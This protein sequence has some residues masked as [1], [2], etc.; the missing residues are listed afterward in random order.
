MNLF[1]AVLSLAGLVTEC[2][3]A[4]GSYRAGTA[5]GA[6]LTTVGVVAGVHDGAA[7]GGRMPMCGVWSLPCR[8]RCWR[9]DVADLADDREASRRTLR[10]FAGREDER[11]HTVS[12]GHELCGNAGGAGRLSA[13]LP[14]VELDVVDNGH[15]QGC[16]P[17]A[18]R[19]PA[20]S[21]SGLDDLVPGL[22]SD[23]GEDVAQ[24]AVL[25]LDQGIRYAAV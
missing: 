8:W 17:G 7:D 10:Y 9:V 12:P 21:A 13:P 4:P 22:Q 25:V 16:L 15:R 6:F 3:L 1:G 23:R 2:G 20:M 11:S 5:D 24:L 18:V 19:C 14:G